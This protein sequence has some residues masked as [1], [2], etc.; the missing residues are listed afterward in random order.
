MVVKPQTS[1]VVL[2]WPPALCAKLM[3]LVCLSFFCCCF[4]FYCQVFECKYRLM[5]NYESLRASWHLFNW[6]KRS[7]WVII[8]TIIILENVWRQ[9]YIMCWVWHVSVNGTLLKQHIWS[10]SSK[11]NNLVVCVRSL[12][13]LVHRFSLVVCM[14]PQT[15]N[16]VHVDGSCFFISSEKK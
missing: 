2:L 4:F 15:A 9:L 14:S 8:L 6:L 7:Y 16:H 12:T 13:G 1:C 5:K 10:C 11:F 3:K